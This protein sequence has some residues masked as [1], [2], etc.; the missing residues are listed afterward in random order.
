MM[1]VSKKL[2]NLQD[3][4]SLTILRDKRKIMQRIMSFEFPSSPTS[5]TESLDTPCVI[6]ILFVH[7]SCAGSIQF[8][9]LIHSLSHLCYKLDLSD[10]KENDKFEQNKINSSRSIIKL[11]CYLFDSLGCGESK[12][13]TYNWKDYSEYELATDLEGIFSS[14]TEKDNEEMKDV[15]IKTFIVAH[16]YGTSQV[17]KLVNS[18]SLYQNSSSVDGIVLLGSALG[19]GPC[20]AIS[21]GGHILFKLPIF[22]LRW[23]Q[24][25]MTKTFVDAAYFIDSEQSLKDK[26]TTFCNQNDMA[27]VKAFYRQVKWSTSIDAMNVKVSFCLWKN[28][29]RSV[30]LFIRQQKN[31][32]FPNFR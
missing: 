16:S 30:K 19:D 12:Q 29:Q 23:M 7:G 24:P 4:R 32:H 10:T 9:S 2:P 25:S 28:S 17:I 11:N 31:I 22:L 14:M 27:M 8:E 13:E 3:M 26:A 1:S 21:D 20:D 18:M 15:E 5:L 6:R